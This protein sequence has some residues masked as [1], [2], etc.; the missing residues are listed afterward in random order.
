MLEI[1]FEILN[2]F[3]DWYQ[4]FMGAPEGITYALFGSKKKKK[5]KKELN[6]ALETIENLE[7]QGIGV[8]ELGE[9]ATLGEGTFGEE[10]GSEEEIIDVPYKPSFPYTGR[11]I[12]IDSGRV[13]LNAKDDFILLMSKKSISLSS[14]G[15]VNIDSNSSF[16]VNSN[17]IKLGINATEPLVL[18]NRLALTLK[19][20]GNILKQ[21]EKVL[22]KPEDGQGTIL[23]EV[24]E[25]VILLSNVAE[26]LTKESL[27]ITSTKNFTE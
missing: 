20:V 15:S 13:H 19:K 26:I 10:D 16:V 18:G 1:I 23:P 4:N 6:K 22:N 24:R 2:N 7:S 25:L 8:D 5:A 9:P 12:I 3:I 21:T 27:L 17:R 11:Q 14:Q